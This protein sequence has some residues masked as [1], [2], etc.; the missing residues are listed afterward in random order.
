VFGLAAWLIFAQAVPGTAVPEEASAT[1]G[2]NHPNRPVVRVNGHWRKKAGA[3]PQYIPIPAAV[4][5]AVAPA[6]A[7]PAPSPPAPAETAAP[8]VVPVPVAPEPPRA[9]RRIH[10]RRRKSID[11]SPALP[12]AKVTLDLRAQARRGPWTIR[13]ANQGDVPTRVLAD[14]RLLSFDVTPRGEARRIRCE[15]PEGMVPSDASEGAVVLPPHRTIVQTFDPRLY[16]FGPKA[17]SAL[18]PGA[19]VVAHLAARDLRDAAPAAVSPLDDVTPAVGPLRS[20][21]TAPIALP[22]DPTPELDGEW[23]H[24]VPQASDNRLTLTGPETSDALSAHEIAISVTLRN[25]GSSPVTVRFRP[26]TLGFDVSGPGM[27]QRCDWPVLPTSPTRELYE[28]VAAHG[29]VDLTLEL[30]AYCDDPAFEQAGIYSVRPW[31]DTRKASG[32]SIGLRTFDGTVAG[33]RATLV[34]VQR[35]ARHEMI[36][37]PA[38]VAPSTDSP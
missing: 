5:E 11:T 6:A 14:P 38:I 29:S 16:C 31:L 17:L 37:P 8:Q 32:N 34:R 10:A 24:T 4:P 1:V 7:T 22:D 27:S 25:E 15:L 13:F 2:E 18:A 33:E 36:A 35:S 3:Q 21:D 9:A 23:P 26:D 19:I 28:T 20:L 30:L 12:P